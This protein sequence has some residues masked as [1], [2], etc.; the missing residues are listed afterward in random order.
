MGEIGNLMINEVKTMFVISWHINCIRNIVKQIKEISKAIFCG[1]EM[2][3]LVDN[4]IS[5]L[6]HIQIHFCNSNLP[7]IEITAN[8][9]IKHIL[10]D[11]LNCNYIAIIFLIIK[12]QLYCNWF[13]VIGEKGPDPNT[14][15]TC[16]MHVCLFSNCF[17]T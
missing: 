11:M 13:F 1:F 17:D 6:I 3:I 12:L 5:P 4:I 7:F 16:Q 15:Y 14:S 2:I 10:I 9:K 8:I